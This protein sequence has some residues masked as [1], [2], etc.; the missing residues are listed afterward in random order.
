M[1]RFQANKNLLTSH[2]KLKLDVAFELGKGELLTLYGPSGAGKTTILRIL[3]GLTD[4]ISGQIIIDGETWLDTK[5]KINLPPQNRSVGFVF[6]DFALFPHLSVKGNLRYALPKGDD[7]KLM[8]ELIQLMELGP[9]QDVRPA[10]LSGGQQQRVALARAILRK[11]RLLLLD[12]PLSALD[13][14]MRH[15][16]QDF[17]ERIRHRFEL[18][19]V[20]VS[21]HM[22]EILRLSDKIIWLDKGKIKREG[23]PAALFSNSKTPDT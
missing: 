21:H 6:Q 8:D 15:R 13:D 12:E 19:T 1:I 7:M 9:L 20:L 23:T 18:T 3:S 5:Q 16:L 17:I 2:G 4:V 14:D 11:P 10:F 22:P